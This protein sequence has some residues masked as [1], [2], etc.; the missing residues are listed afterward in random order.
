M[1][2]S[3]LRLPEYQGYRDKQ[4]HAES[5]TEMSDLEVN[6][7]QLFDVSKKTTQKRPKKYK[8]RVHTRKA[9]PTFKVKRLKLSV[10]QPAD[11]P[12]IRSRMANQRQQEIEQETHFPQI[13]AGQTSFPPSVFQGA[14]QRSSI[15]SIDSNLD[16]SPSPPEL[17]QEA[18]W[19]VP[20]FQVDIP[21]RGYNIAPS[22]TPKGRTKFEESRYSDVGEYPMVNRTR[23]RIRKNWVAPMR[24]ELHLE[25]DQQLP[26]RMGEPM[27]ASGSDMLD[28]LNDLDDLFSDKDVEMDMNEDNMGK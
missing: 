5:E 9:Q 12:P 4:E 27:E 13:P 24:S 28:Y 6:E 20:M 7:P 11:V 8:G 25:D 21:E 18:N 3:I 14:S 17:V 2:Q 19:Q 26:M 15:V 16:L 23:E 10:E 1:L 22:Q